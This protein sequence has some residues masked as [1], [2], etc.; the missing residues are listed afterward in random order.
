MPP[1]P[2][3]RSSASSVDPVVSTVDS[4]RRIIRVL[5]LNAHRTEAEFGVSGAQLF[6]LQQLGDDTLSL[7]DLAARTMTDRT[8]VSGVVDRLVAEGLVDRA[9]DPNDRRRSA[10]RATAAGRRLLARAPVAP[11]SSLLVAL[12]A[13]PEMEVRG[14]AASLERL[15][16]ALGAE[17]E[18]ALLL[19][20]EAAPRPRKSR[21]R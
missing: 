1:R 2:R 18:P 14:L 20:A 21:R 9:T 11:T 6:V 7:N 19:F 4:L 3:H 8:S 12:R 15:T 13:L 10:I 5:R 16:R 17:R